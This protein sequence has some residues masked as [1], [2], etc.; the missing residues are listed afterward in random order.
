MRKNAANKS[1]LLLVV[2]VCV[3]AVQCSAPERESRS[4]K[5]TIAIAFRNCLGRTHTHTHRIPAHLIISREWVSA[6]CNCNNKANWLS[7]VYSV[8]C[9][10]FVCTSMRICY[11]HVLGFNLKSK[12][13]SSLVYILCYHSIRLLYL[14]IWPYDISV[15]LFGNEICEMFIWMYVICHVLS[16]C[17]TYNIFV[18]MH[19]AQMKMWIH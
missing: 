14:C 18:C 7:R 13:N 9:S 6:Y 1:C 10:I 12:K 15:Y 17:C 2:R 5:G 11:Q 3:N 16:F 19:C 8:Y 4:E